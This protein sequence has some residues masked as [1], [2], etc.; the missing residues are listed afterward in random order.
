MNASSYKSTLFFCLFSTLSWKFEGI[1]I[2]T[3]LLWSNFKNQY[4]ITKTCNNSNKTFTWGKQNSCQHAFT[5][6]RILNALFK[7]LCSIEKN[8]PMFRISF[9]YCLLVNIHCKYGRILCDKFVINV[10]IN[11]VEIKWYLT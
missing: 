6:W 3:I 8:Q 10:I 4:E 5:S 7:D 2:S 11:N 1:T 9:S